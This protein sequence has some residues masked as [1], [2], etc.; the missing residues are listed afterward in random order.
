MVKI[1]CC[2]MVLSLCCW[3]GPPLAVAQSSSASSAAAAGTL[4]QG[5]VP[6]SPDEFPPLALATRRFEIISLGVFPF[7]L[8]YTRLAFDLQRYASNNFQSIYAPWPFKNEFSYKPSDD[9]QIRSLLIAGGVSLAFAGV[10]A[11][12]RHYKSRD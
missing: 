12:V 5:A 8:F 11:F 7:A 1:V 10:E 3:S 4:V 6:Y 9:E 2:L